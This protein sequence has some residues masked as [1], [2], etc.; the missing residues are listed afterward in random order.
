MEEEDSRQK[1]WPLQRQKYA[2]GRYNERRA[3]GDEVRERVKK[4]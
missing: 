1:E 4:R 3:K 2:V